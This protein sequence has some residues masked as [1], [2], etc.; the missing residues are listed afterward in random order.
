[1]DNLTK[2]KGLLNKEKEETNYVRSLC[3]VMQEVGG[4]EQLMNLTLPALSE[5][6]KARVYF[7]KEK[8][9]AAKKK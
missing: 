7:E 5:I 9:K 4:Y 1:M 8:A 6:I 3:Y 2:L